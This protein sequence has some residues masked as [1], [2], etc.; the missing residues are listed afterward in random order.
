[1]KS[2]GSRPPSPRSDPAAA[3]AQ[4]PFARLKQLKKQ[5]DQARRDAAEREAKARA[6]HERAQRERELFERTVGPVQRLR[7]TGRAHIDRPLPAPLPRQREMDE[8]SVLR[9]SMSDEMDVETLLETDDS[10]S[11]RRRGVGPQVLKRLRRGEWSIQAEIDLHGLRR[12][13]ARE[14]LG[15]FLREAVKNGLRC[16][17]VVH[18]K[19]LGSPGR[20]PVLKG[21]VKAWLV[22]RIEVMAFTQARASEGGAG[23]LVVLLGGG[24]PA[25][26]P[27]QGP[28]IRGETLR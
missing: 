10:L 27:E 15:A 23:A 21:K 14:R 20:E 18:G 6:I 1:M 2:R 9:E 26:P 11:F 8:R 28:P 25:A 5:M 3:A 12:D 13:E 16:V 17:R 19:G 24:V 4:H 7:E 22:Q